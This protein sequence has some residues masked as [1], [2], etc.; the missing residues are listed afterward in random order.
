[1]EVFFFLHLLASC[2]YHAII[3]VLLIHFT[4]RKRSLSKKNGKKELFFR[5]H[6]SKYI[7]KNE[8]RL[9]EIIQMGFNVADTQIMW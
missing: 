7:T 4:V 9:N 5:T 2:E 1:M 3:Y 8:N 6:E